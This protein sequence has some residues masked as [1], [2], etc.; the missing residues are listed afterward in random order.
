[1]QFSLGSESDQPFC[2]L[3]EGAL[4]SFLAAM[5]MYQ[6]SYLGHCICR[7]GT[8]PCQLDNADV[9]YI[10]ADKGNLFRQ[11][12]IAFQYHCQ[13]GSFVLNAQVQFRNVQLF[14][15]L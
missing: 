4:S 8:K 14:R 6:R 13:Q 5:I 12:A 10:V 1:M 7:A 9:V 15:T 3:T 2:K 11:Q